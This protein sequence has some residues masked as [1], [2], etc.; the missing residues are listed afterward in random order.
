M[1]D[2]VRSGPIE[3]QTLSE[4]REFAKTCAESGF[5]GAVNPQQALV[6]AMAGRDLGFSY[7]QALRAF[8]VLK[9]K[10]TLSADGMVAACLARGVCEYFRPVEVTE[11]S[12][13]WETRRVG[14]DPVRYTFTMQDAE[15]AGLLSDMYRRHPKRMLSA[16]CKA[17]LARD[18]Y[19]EVL[20]GLVTEDEADEISGARQSAPR[21]AQRPAPAPVVVDAVPVEP[22][23]A[24]DTA[25]QAATLYQRIQAC[26]TVEALSTLWRDCAAYR[27]SLPHAEQEAVKASFADR[28]RELGGAS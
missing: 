5:F 9:G 28:K 8:H 14:C 4:L 20:M 23:P 13:T 10:P 22:S 1:S 24:D 19:P 6:I 12:A 21:T 7:T 17:Y 2:L 16:R 25:Q 3:P 27:Q 18:V 15:R 11:Q 26:E